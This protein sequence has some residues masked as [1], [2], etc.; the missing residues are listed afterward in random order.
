MWWP[1]P[2][3]PMPALRL[4]AKVTYP[5][6]PHA[7]LSNARRPT[8]CP[9]GKAH[10]PKAVP[11]QHKKGKDMPPLPGHDRGLYNT[12]LAIWLGDKA[13]DSTLRSNLLGRPA[14]SRAAA[15]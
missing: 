6:P 13:S 2:T 1:P 10:Q 8:A 14:A 12:L 11:D 9:S 15:D 3:W 7:T 4:Q 5:K